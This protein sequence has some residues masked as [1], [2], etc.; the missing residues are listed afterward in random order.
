[1]FC[2]YSKILKETF[3]FAVCMYRVSTYNIHIMTLIAIRTAVHFK[4]A[5]GVYPLVWVASNN[6]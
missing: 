1:M 4:L 5:G 6:I 3:L 2:R